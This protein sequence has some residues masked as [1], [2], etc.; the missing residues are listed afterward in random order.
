MLTILATSSEKVLGSMGDCELGNELKGGYWF[1]CHFQQLRS[2]HDE[3]E[4]LNREEITYSLQIFPRGLS[5][6]EA[7]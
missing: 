1:L 7:P 3:I 2:Y 6:A 5:V 4:T